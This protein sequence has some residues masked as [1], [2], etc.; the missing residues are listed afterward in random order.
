MSGYKPTTDEVR[1]EF[2]FAHQDVDMDGNVLV[3]LDEA[4]ARWGRWLAEVKRAAAAKALTD[5]ADELERANA[6]PNLIELE[7][8]YA[9]FYSGIRS[10]TASNVEKLRTRAAA[11]RREET[12]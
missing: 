6:S 12:E 8:M 9:G 3:S 1:E 5:A 4:F 10:T 7:S 2:V 11:Y